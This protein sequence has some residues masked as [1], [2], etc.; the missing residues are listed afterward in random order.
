MKYKAQI[1][2]KLENIDTTLQRVITGLNTS[3]LTASQ[4]IEICIKIK[5][6]D[7]QSIQELVSIS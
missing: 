3:T 6:Q 5:S 2:T 4:V 7:I 1:S